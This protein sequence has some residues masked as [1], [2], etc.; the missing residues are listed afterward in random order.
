MR[1]AVFVFSILLIFS[2]TYAHALIWL[3]AVKG[4]V[5]RTAA[6]KVIKVASKK[7]LVGSI[8]FAGGFAGSWVSDYCKKNQKKCKDAIG[9]VADWFFDDETNQVCHYDGKQF[10]SADDVCAYFFKKVNSRNHQGYVY[11]DRYKATSGMC[12]VY[13]GTNKYNGNVGA[14]FHCTDKS[15]VISQH[16]QKIIQYVKDNDPDYIINNYGDQINIDKYC[17]TAGACAELDQSF[18]DEVMNNKNKYDI[19]KINKD[20]CEVRD[21][22]ITSC[23]KAKKD[24]DD[25][26]SDTP[27]DTDTKPKDDGDDGK[28]GGDDNDSSSKDK[29][30]NKINCEAS[31]FHKKV[32]DF[33]DWYQDDADLKD[34]DK[35]EIKELSNE[36]KID[37]DKVSF[38]RVCP[39][40]KTVSI[41][42]GNIKIVKQLS[43]QGLCDAFIKMKPFVVGVG[44]IVGA[45]IVVGRRV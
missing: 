17:A 20:N 23:D 16:T 39:A 30:D 10:A 5:L 42:F 27:K 15:Q 8:S 45:M 14:S 28:D 9:D 33:I 24:T 36:L 12:L 19:D 6:G 41:G 18:G 21:G 38:G 37:D 13:G 35:V 4:A 29:D 34:G 11:A 22:K 40:G 26:D 43:Y 2:T 32:C 25:D 44:W 7:A 31:A 3:P 1:F